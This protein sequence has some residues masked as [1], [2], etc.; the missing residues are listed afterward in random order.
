M[1]PAQVPTPVNSHTFCRSSTLLMMLKCYV[2]RNRRLITTVDYCNCLLM[3]T[4]KSSVI[5]TL[6]KIQNFAAR[7][8]LLPSRH[9]RSTPLLEKL[10]WLPISKRIKRK[11]ACMCFS[12]INGSGPSYL[13]KLLHVYTPSRTLRSSS[14]TRML[15]IQQYKRKTHGF[16]TFSCFGPHTFGIHKTL[17]T[18]QPCHLLKPN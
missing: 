5:Q 9:H 6:Q 10:H 13:S 18:A 14:D 17:D 15:E 7:F 16:R 2:H 12:A 1:G 11:V 3:G 4:P 8:V